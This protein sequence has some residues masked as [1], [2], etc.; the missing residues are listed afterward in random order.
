MQTD[1]NNQ[2][3]AP[4][5][6]NTASQ[7]ADPN[8]TQPQ[9]AAPAAAVE[10]KASH[11]P[12]ITGIILGILSLAASGISNLM[13]HAQYTPKGPTTG[14]VEAEVGHAVATGTTSILGAIFGMPFIVLGVVLG[15]ASI[16]FTVLRLRKVRAAGLIVSI[17]VILLVVWSMSIAV[18]SL[19]YIK[20]DPA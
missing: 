19:N 11:K 4:D 12:S 14:S 7:T 18:D 6:T 13:V 5:I 9:V 16:L 10:K 2:G 3:E 15:L 1:P 20:A 17:L 8:A